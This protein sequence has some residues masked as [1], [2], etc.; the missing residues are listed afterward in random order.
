MLSIRCL[1]AVDSP[2][3]KIAVKT[4]VAY[5]LWLRRNLKHAELVGADTLDGSFELFASEQLPALAGL[6]SKHAEDLFKAPGSFRV[7]VQA[8]YGSPAGDCMP[9]AAGW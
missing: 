2:G 6:R 9:E 4:G 5:E 8:V 7:A 1:T 3:V